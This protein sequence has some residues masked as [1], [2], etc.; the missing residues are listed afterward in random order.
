LLNPMVALHMPI[1]QMGGV[2]RSV[3]KQTSRVL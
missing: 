1:S 2:L 3:F